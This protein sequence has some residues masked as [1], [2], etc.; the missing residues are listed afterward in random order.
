MHQPQNLT[1]I[2]QNQYQRAVEVIAFQQHLNDQVIDHEVQQRQQQ[3]LLLLHV[4][5]FVRV[6]VAEIDLN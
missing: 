4:G 5:N 1:L 2:I 3:P 6:F